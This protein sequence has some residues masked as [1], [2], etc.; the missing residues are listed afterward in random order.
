MDFNWTVYDD[1]VTELEGQNISHVFPQPGNFT[2]GVS[3]SNGYSQDTFY[4]VV[5]VLDPITDVSSWHTVNLSTGFHNLDK[6][7]T[8]P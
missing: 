3:A 1:P 2:I 5:M 8:S 7:Q 4:N 6:H